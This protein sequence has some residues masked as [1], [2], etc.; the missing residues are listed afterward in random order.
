MLPEDTKRAFEKV[1]GFE[2]PKRRTLD[3]VNGEKGAFVQLW[4]RA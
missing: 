2:R 1:T 4:R 3:P